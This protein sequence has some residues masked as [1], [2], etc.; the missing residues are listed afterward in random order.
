MSEQ[1]AR[2]VVYILQVKSDK[3]GNMMMLGALKMHAEKVDLSG[4]EFWDAL[5]FA[6]KDGWLVRGQE[7]STVTLTSKGISQK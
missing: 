6:E 7:A 3:P 5:E 2:K 4:T 1:G